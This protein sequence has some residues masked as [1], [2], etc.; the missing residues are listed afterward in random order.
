MINRVFSNPKTRIDSQVNQVFLAID[1]NGKYFLK[2]KHRLSRA[3]TMPVGVLCFTGGG[4]SRFAICSCFYRRGKMIIA[5]LDAV[6]SKNPSEYEPVLF[7]HIMAFKNNQYTKNARIVIMVENNLG[8]ESF[9]IERFIKRTKARPFCCFLTD[10]DQK[11]GLRTTNPIKEAM[12]HKFKT[13]LEEDA[14]FIWDSLI[15]V[16]TAYNPKEMLKQLKEELNNYKVMIE[17]PKQ[18]CVRAL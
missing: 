17:L 3:N 16:N 9:H 6:K 12:W 15:S 2:K 5:G 4:D 7:D 11:V 14:V 1:P 8:F 10:K 18:V 13:F